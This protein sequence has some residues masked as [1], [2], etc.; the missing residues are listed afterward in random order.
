MPEN[1]ES[2]AGVASPVRE[3]R[4]GAAWS[5]SC[6]QDAH[7]ET[8]LVRCAQESRRSSRHHLRVAEAIPGTGLD[9]IGLG[10]LCLAL[11][12]G[13]AAAIQESRTHDSGNGADT[14]HFSPFFFRALLRRFRELAW[15][16]IGLLCLAMI[17]KNGIE[18]EQV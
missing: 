4:E 14:V 5:S 7:D 18:Q 10:L 13:R 12:G 8:A 1:A 17:G 16:G 9:W 6:S 15:I 2:R 11:V 3:G